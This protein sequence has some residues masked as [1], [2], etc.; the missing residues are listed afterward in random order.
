MELFGGMVNLL[1]I[2]AVA[3]H[4]LLSRVLPFWVPVVRV[5]SVSGC[6]CPTLRYPQQGLTLPCATML[7]HMSPER[8][9][10]LLAPFLG[11]E[12]LADT[13]IAQVATYLDLLTKWNAKMNLTAVR[14]PEQMVQRHFGESFFAARQIFPDKGGRATVADIGSGAGF[15]GVP[16]KLWAPAI[17]LS[18]I[19]AQQKKAAFLGEAIRTLGLEGIKVMRSRAEQIEIRFDVVTLRAVESFETI[20]PIAA[21]LVRPAGRLVLLIGAGQATT[22][23]SL[24]RQITWSA[25]ISIPLS[26]GRVVLIGGV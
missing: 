26:S 5:R 8:I 21:R 9:R 2:L 10:E 24:M 12:Q 22:A 11:Q 20:L 17:E 14:D 6:A 3:S 15:P 25:P 4:L 23:S 19:E 16:I 18:L 13:Q 1:G 7:G